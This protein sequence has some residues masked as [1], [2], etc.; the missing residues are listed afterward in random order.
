VAQLFGKF[1]GTVTDVFD[2]LDQARV[3]VDVP[4]AGITA[5]WAVPCFPL[6]GDVAIAGLPLMGD[7]VWV[8]FEEGDPERPIWT[9]SPTP[10]TNGPLV[11]GDILLLAGKVRLATSSGGEV[12]V[13]GPTVSINNGAVEVF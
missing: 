6:G 2:P 12:V 4:S 3:Q 10:P 11:P 8:E 7:T 5:S 1:R 13:D 9:G